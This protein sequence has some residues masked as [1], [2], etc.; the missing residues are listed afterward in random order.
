MRQSER[1]WHVVR[2]YGMGEWFMA[3]WVEGLEVWEAARRLG[4]SVADVDDSV[5]CTWTDLL[6]ERYSD[7]EG[8]V[9]AGRLTAD[10]TQIIQVQGFECERALRELSFGGRA[11]LVGW[12]LNGPRDLEYAVNGEYVTGLSVTVPGKRWGSDPQA[13]D[14]YLQGLQFDWGDSSWEDDP[15]LPAGWLEY[16]AWEEA[17]LES[18]ED[19][20][21]A[22]IPDEW[23]DFIGLACNGY[24]PPLAT[25]L[26]SAL[27]LVGRVTGRE[28]DREW[29]YGA[30]T[31]YVIR[32]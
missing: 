21:E 25:C 32:E 7:G 13:L 10:W 14:P 12:D 1:L 16:C 4:V 9:W 29:M 3:A 26:T 22:E 30:H 17:R 6:R 20:G 18:G 8:V 27:A 19:Y 28:I 5:E 2:S 31:R 24:S 15:D 11:L 23:Q